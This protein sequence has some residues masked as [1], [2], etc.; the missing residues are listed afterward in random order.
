METPT[1]LIGMD[2]VMKAVPYA[3]R[4]L[5]ERIRRED[6]DVWIDGRDRR[7]RLIRRA[8]LPKLIEPRPVE[9]RDATAA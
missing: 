7:R 4:A 6:I 8:D 1:D 9:R 3:R 5:I 2:E